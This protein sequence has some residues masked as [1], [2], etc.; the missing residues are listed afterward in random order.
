M[1]SNSSLAS[2]IPLGL[3]Q[4]MLCCMVLPGRYSTISFCESSSVLFLVTLVRDTFLPL[5]YI[6]ANLTSWWSTSLLEKLS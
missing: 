2:I 4:V 5:E 1:G 6:T 3:Y